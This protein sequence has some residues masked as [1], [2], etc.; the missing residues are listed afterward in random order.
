[1]KPEPLKLTL[2]LNITYYPAPQNVRGILQE[3]QILLA[4]NKEHEKVFPEIP[5]VGFCNGKRLSGYDE[6]NF[7]KIDNDIG[8]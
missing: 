4:F 2:L 1:M 3:L 6:S 7:A 5:I 8:P